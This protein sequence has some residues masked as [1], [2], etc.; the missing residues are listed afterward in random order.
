MGLTDFGP[1]GRVFLVMHRDFPTVSPDDP[2]E[3]GLAL[4]S[5]GAPVVPVVAYGQLT[6][7]LTPEHLSEFVRI[8]GRHWHE[9]P[10][11]HEAHSRT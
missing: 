11:D 4:L 7:L 5:A 1:D 10:S 2:A 9:E 3:R 8:G 6:G